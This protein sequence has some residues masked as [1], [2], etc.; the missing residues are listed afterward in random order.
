ML[1]IPTISA[2]SSRALGG[3]LELAL[4]TQFRVFSPV[5]EAGLPETR[6]GIIPGARGTI[7]LPEIVGRTR[8][9]DMVLTGRRVTGVEALRIGLCD[10]LCGTVPEASSDN[11]S[12]S[13]MREAVLEGA[14]KMATEICEGA[15]G[16]VGPAMKAVYGSSDSVADH[17]YQNVV[18]SEDR[19]EGLRAFQ[20]KRKPQYKG[21]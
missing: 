11:V 14:L 10:R 13:T 15:P 1:P 19:N 12:D 17:E 20:E 21:R 4:A 6:L 18:K 3:G 16:A 9:A 2:V 7:R 8:A 5:T